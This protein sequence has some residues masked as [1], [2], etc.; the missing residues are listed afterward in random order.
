MKQ[1]LFE[2]RQQAELLLREAIAIWRQSSQNDLLEGIENDPVFS[3]L[4]TALAYQLNDIDYDIERLK[5]EVLEDYAKMLVPYDMASAQPA[6]AVVTTNLQPSTTALQM[7]ERQVFRLNGTY[8]FIPLLSTRVLGVEDVSVVR[9][10]AR[11][12]KVRLQFSSPVT[13]L[14]GFSFAITQPQF[15]DLR[16]TIGGK[17][18]PLYKPWHY[19]DLPYAKSFALDTVLYSQSP[20]FN[21]ANA[22]L[23]LFARQNVRVFTVKHHQPA[24]FI[25]HETEEIDLVLEFSGIA[26]DFVLD[27]PAFAPNAVMLVNAISHTAQLSADRPIV[28]VTGFDEQEADNGEQFMQMTRPAAE[29]IFKNLTVDVRTVAADRFNRSSLLRLLNCLVDKFGSDYY[30]FLQLQQQFNDSIILQV[31]DGLQKLQRA[32]AE[33]PEDNVAGTY[34]MLRQDEIARNSG[35]SLQVEYLTTNGALLNSALSDD[36]TFAV[37]SGLD[38][39]ATRLLAT[40]VG[41]TNEM[42]ERQQLDSLSRYY[43]ATRDR[44]VTPADLKIFCYNELMTRYGISADMVVSINVRNCLQDTLQGYGYVT[45]V[46][47]RLHDTPFIKRHFTEKISQAELFIQKMA[48]VRSTTVYPM[49]VNISINDYEA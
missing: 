44:I 32:C 37:P 48:E 40:P 39:S 4:L 23:D 35:A 27:K 28:R 11:C 22:W 15:T 3:L 29:Q 47:I 1:S 36:N 34:L 30:A 21:A 25:A 43:F 10:D 33:T 41:G 14:S 6:T 17:L 5:Q 46:E 49:Q 31:R 20:V 26:D 9:L 13:D 18:V 45:Q 19:A 2:I 24:M 12:W 8:L 42:T 16:V 7:D 38:A